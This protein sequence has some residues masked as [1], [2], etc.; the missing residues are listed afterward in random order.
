M[1][2]TSKQITVMCQELVQHGV[3]AP[4]AWQHGKLSI[5]EAVRMS[6]EKTFEP[7]RRAGEARRAS[8]RRNA[9]DKKE[10]EEKKEE[11]C[12]TCG[13]RKVIPE[14]TGPGNLMVSKEVIRCPKC[15]TN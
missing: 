15:N 11:A 1:N 9:Q 12:E 6:L 3:I 8:Q 5:I 7:A 4:L 2:I 14:F 10:R 13:G